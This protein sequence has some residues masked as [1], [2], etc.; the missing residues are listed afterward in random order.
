MKLPEVPNIH[1]LKGQIIHKVIEKL[2]SNR[3]YVDPV[4]FVNKELDKLWN[5]S[6]LNLSKEDEEKHK[7]D[8]RAILTLFADSYKKKIEAMLLDEKFSDIDHIWNYLRPVMNEVN[9]DSDA[10]GLTGRIDS[11]E[12]DK[13]GVVSLVDYKTSKKYR[14]HI[15]EDYMRQIRLYAL[16]YY[17]ENKK[18]PAYVILHFIRYGEIFHFPVTPDTIELAKKDLEFVKL[19]TCSIEM[20][21][22]PQNITNFCEWCDYRNECFGK[23]DKQEVLKK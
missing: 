23:K 4:E 19:N 7:K 8:A 12:I 17:L 21:D 2:F 20:K 10:L 3:K 18:P 9:F 22:Y 15:R 6:V 16:L 11:I 1:S 5:V 14:H 13:D